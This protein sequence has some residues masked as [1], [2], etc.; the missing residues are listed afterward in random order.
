MVGLDPKSL[1]QC[2]QLFNSFQREARKN[3]K[4]VLKN[5]CE[6]FLDKINNFDESM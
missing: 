1:L 5:D 4:R 6:R 2:Y 3:M